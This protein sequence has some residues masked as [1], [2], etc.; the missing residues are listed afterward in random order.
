MHTQKGCGRGV[1]G[2]MY[3]LMLVSCGGF[4]HSSVKGGLAEAEPQ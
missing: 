3:Y 2:M 1:L 4:F